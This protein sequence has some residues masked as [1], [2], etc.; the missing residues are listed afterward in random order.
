MLLELIQTCERFSTLRAMKAFFHCVHVTNMSAHIFCALERLRASRFLTPKVLLGHM[1]KLMFAQFILI[2][3][4]LAA[5]GAKIVV[6][7]AHH[8]LI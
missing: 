3:E 8:M 4:D 5:H 6:L 2:R 1:A 7:C